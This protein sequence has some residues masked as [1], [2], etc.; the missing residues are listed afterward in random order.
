MMK[1]STFALVLGCLGGEG[2]V[3]AAWLFFI[4]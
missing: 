3:L 1:I 4:G 2:I